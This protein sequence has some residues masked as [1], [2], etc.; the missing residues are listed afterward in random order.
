MAAM[1][2]GLFSRNGVHLSLQ[3]APFVFDS[4]R[5]IVIASGKNDP[6]LYSQAD[7]ILLPHAG[8][9]RHAVVMMDAE[10][11]GSPGPVAIRR[12][13]N[14]HLNRAGWGEER[15]LGLVIEPEV[16]AWLWTDSPHTPEALGWSSW[17]ALRESLEPEGW[18]RPGE[19]KPRRPKEAAERALRLKGLSRSS[20]V[21]AQ[22]A[23]RVSLPKCQEPSAITLIQTLRSWFP[24]GGAE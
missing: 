6:G 21:Y 5:D 12:R 16:D 13:L 22:V 9:F 23:G 4:K 8:L 11:G 18:L 15:G 2:K 20:D 1:V 24:P 3:T 10:W 7:A 19:V 17:Q 14:E